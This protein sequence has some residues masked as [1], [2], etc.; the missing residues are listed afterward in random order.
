MKDDVER[1]PESDIAGR[2]AKLMDV[3]ALYRDRLRLDVMVINTYNAI[4]KIDPE[5]R[6]ASDELAAKYR[7]LGRWNDLIAVLARRA[8]AADLIDAD[9]IAQLREIADLWA[10]RFGNFANAIKPLERILELCRATPIAS[11]RTQGHLYATAAVAPADRRARSRGRHAD[12]RRAA[13]QAGRDGAARRRAPRR[14]Q[15]VDRDP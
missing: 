12:R 8:E 9:R 1:L 15:A 6:R 14:H 10:E 4:L 11:S 5:N 13:H 2:V 7:A 3:V